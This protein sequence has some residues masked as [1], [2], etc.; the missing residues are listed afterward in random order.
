MVYGL[1]RQT[2]KA[3]EG[4]LNWG[5]PIEL[6]R[7]MG[8]WASEYMGPGRQL[9]VAIGTGYMNW[10]LRVGVG[11]GDALPCQPSSV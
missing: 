6:V 11:L 3:I 10:E 8:R 4:W 5:Y 9:G 1:A 7:Y 2:G